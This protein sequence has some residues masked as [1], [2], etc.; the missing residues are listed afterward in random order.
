MHYFR[1]GHILEKMFVWLIGFQICMCPV[2]LLQ[3]IMTNYHSSV[4]FI[5]N[6][7]LHYLIVNFQCSSNP[8]HHPLSYFSLN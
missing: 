6:Q 1:M 5:V 3:K 7:S 2:F 4:E 8:Y